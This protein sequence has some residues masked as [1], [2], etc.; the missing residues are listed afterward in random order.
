MILNVSTLTY[1]DDPNAYKKDKTCLVCKKSFSMMGAMKKHYCKFCF[2]GVCAG[3]SKHRAPD[4]TTKN[5]RICDSCYQRAIQDQVR[6]NLQKDLDKVNKELEELKKSFASEKEQRKH[7]SFRRDTLEQ[8]LK[9]VKME[10]ERREKELNDTSEN[11]KKDIKMMEQEIEELTR[12]LSTAEKE[13]KERETKIT[14]LKVE[15]NLMKNE[16]QNDTVKIND[17]KRLISEQEL[18]NE[19]L[20]KELNSRAELPSDLED[21]LNRTSLLDGLK[22]KCAQAKEQHKE[23]KKENETLK[24]KLAVVREENAKK[25]DELAKI[26]ENAARKRTFSKVT[27]DTKDLE[28]QIAYQEQEIKRLQDKLEMSS[29]PK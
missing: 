25:K 29:T 5:V 10:N 12:I 2:H 23:L 1:G 19:N 14:A 22:A 27:S 24:K 17:L 26:E 3:C 15:I 18:E 6:D 7:E 13:K 20:T 9:E 4:I 28:D 11:M 8:K 16:T 21:P